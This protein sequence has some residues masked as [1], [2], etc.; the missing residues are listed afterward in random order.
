ML[1]RVLR[2]K[3]FTTSKS[4]SQS[5]TLQKAPRF[6][7]EHAAVSKD[8]PLVKVC[9]AAPCREGCLHAQLSNAGPQCAGQVLLVGVDLVSQHACSNLCGSCCMCTDLAGAALQDTVVSEAKQCKELPA[10]AGDQLKPGNGAAGAVADSAYAPP[11]A[12][13]AG[14]AAKASPHKQRASGVDQPDAGDCCCLP[15]LEVQSA[16]LQCV[17]LLQHSV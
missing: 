12:Q 14:S 2:Q 11:A 4:G 15:L 10:D 1:Q 9:L 3:E 7:F 17:A 8:K 5:C 16:F 6:I 13:E